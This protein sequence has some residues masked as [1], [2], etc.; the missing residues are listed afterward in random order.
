VA[1]EELLGTGDVLDGDEPA[2]GVVLEHPVHE[3]ERVTAWESA[4]IEPAMSMEVA[5]MNRAIL[6][7]G[8]LSA[9]A[10]SARALDPAGARNGTRGTRVVRHL[11][12]ARRG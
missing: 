1:L 5:F 11:A 3:D 12:V 10:D 4:R 8:D 2:G 7:D 6:V 9:S